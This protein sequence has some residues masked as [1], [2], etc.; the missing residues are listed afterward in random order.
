MGTKLALAYANIFMAEIEEKFQQPAADKIKLWKRFIDNIFVIW[1]GSIEEFNEFMAT[2]N[3]L[4][5]T[6]IHT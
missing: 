5:N 3:T 4:H 2:A 6:K 1:T